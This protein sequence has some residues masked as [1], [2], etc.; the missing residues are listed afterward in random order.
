MVTI[1]RKTEQEKLEEKGLNTWAAREVKGVPKAVCPT[2]LIRKDGTRVDTSDLTEEQIM[3]IINN[4]VKEFVSANKSNLPA[5]SSHLSSFDL[6]EAT[7]DSWTPSIYAILQTYSMQ[8]VYGSI[9][10]DIR[11]CMDRQNVVDKARLIA[12]FQKE[13]VGDFGIPTE[14]EV[15]EVL[16]QM[17]YNEK[18]KHE[19]K[20]SM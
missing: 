13:S 20:K 3:S 17:G 19:R 4:D 1:Y 9:M 6:I 10:A 16:Q 8:Q 12:Q 18:M 14:E 5:S 11:G 7:K 2:Y 15:I